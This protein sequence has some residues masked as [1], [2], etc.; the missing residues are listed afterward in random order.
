ML[1]N[2]DTRTY[3]TNNQQ[4]KNKK[5]KEKILDYHQIFSHGRSKSRLNIFFENFADVGVLLS[6]L[7]F[8]NLA[9]V[10]VPLFL[11][12]TAGAIADPLFELIRAIIDTTAETMTGQTS[13]FFQYQR[14]KENKY[15]EEVSSALLPTFIAQLRQSQQ[16]RRDER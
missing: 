9:I 7:L 8:K 15:I 5:R 6:Y 13:E 16:A 4:N 3:V 1:G 10:N 14:F 2:L 11:T 12:T